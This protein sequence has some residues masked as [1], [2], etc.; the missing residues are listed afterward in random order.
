[1]SGIVAPTAPPS[2]LSVVDAW[3]DGAASYLFAS[4]PDRD[5]VIADYVGEARFGASEI[6]ADLVTLS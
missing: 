2:L 6:A 4:A 1:M 3:L 5:A